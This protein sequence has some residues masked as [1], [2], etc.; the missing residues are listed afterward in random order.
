MEINE[1]IINIFITCFVSIIYIS[2]K[3]I[4]R[5]KNNKYT[6]QIINK[7]NELDIGKFTLETLINE[8]KILIKPEE[9]IKINIE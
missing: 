5:N 1:S 8:I 2:R 6:D 3:Y 9:D 4:R 7:I